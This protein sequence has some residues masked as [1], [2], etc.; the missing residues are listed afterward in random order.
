MPG[1]TNSRQLSDD[2]GN[3]QVDQK[4]DNILLNTPYDHLSDTRKRQRLGCRSGSELEKD[5]GARLLDLRANDAGEERTM[6]LANL[7]PDPSHP[8]GSPLHG[9]RVTMTRRHLLGAP[10]RRS[11]HHSST[12][13]FLVLDAHDPAGC[14]SQLVEE[15]GRGCEAKG[16]RF[17]SLDEINLVPRENTRA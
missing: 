8:F 7:V 2:T 4:L 17:E 1:T 6:L 9:T 13:I 10:R 15:D 5:P 12:S 11:S 16:R 14:R 3:S